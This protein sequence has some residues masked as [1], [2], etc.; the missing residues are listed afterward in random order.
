VARLVGAQVEG[1]ARLRKDV[2]KGLDELRGQQ[3]LRQQQ[4]Q[5]T[6][7]ASRSCN[8]Y[9]HGLHAPAL[10]CA[11]AN[12][13]SGK[14][15]AA[16]GRCARAPAGSRP[17]TSRSPAARP[18]P[19]AGHAATA[20]GCA[21]RGPQSAP[22]TPRA[23]LP[24]PRPPPLRAR[25]SPPAHAPPPLPPPPTRAAAAALLRPRQGCC[26]RPPDQA[27]ALLRLPR[28][29]PLPR[30]PPLPARCCRCAPR[31]AGAAVSPLRPLC[32]LLRGT[33]NYTI[34]H[35]FSRG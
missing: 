15:G 14:V 24:P 20:A 2:C 21:L 33:A 32:W 23:R 25:P 34:R 8:S 27:P 22:H 16:Q 29:Q 35:P 13:T 19:G 11:G 26:W 28:R 4:Q 30:L 18:S 10:A 3:L 1:Q 9:P 7:S 5:R 6:S 17:R 31:A 12:A